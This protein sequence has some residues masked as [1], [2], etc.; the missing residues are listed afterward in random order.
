[1][2]DE[3]HRTGGVG[4]VGIGMPSLDKT[5]FQ[6]H[7][8]MN[9]NISNGSSG[10]STSNPRANSGGQNSIFDRLTNPSYFSGTQKNL[11][12]QV[13]VATPVMVQIAEHVF[14]FCRILMSR[15]LKSSR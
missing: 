8:F 13:R 12:Q 3:I 9:N 15:E 4:A 1:M 2:A 7:N 14:P 5:S 11:F 6:R 10:S